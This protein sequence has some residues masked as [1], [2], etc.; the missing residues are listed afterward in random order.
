MRL[1]LLSDTHGVLDTRIAALAA[2]C[3]YVV[4][5]GD[6][7]S[8]AVLDAL[9]PKHGLL[10]VCGNNDLPGKW[11]TQDHAVL[12]TLSSINELDLPGGKLIVTHGDRY[13][14]RDRHRRLRAAYPHARAIV[15]GHSHRLV[16][17]RDETPWVLNPGAAGRA[18]TF[19]GPSCLLLAIERNKWCVSERRFPL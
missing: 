8:R 3:D 7:G 15:Y 4:H 19:G 1:L 16:I 2:Q 5:A 12:K 6:V 17:D 11:P 10:A 13:P 18:R 9:W 14:S